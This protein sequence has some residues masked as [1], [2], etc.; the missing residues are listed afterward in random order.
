MGV[1]DIPSPYL[2]AVDDWL[3]HFMPAAMTLVLW[4]AAGAVLCMELYRLT[5]PQRHIAEIKLA[6]V[7][8]RRQVA[9]FD[10]EMEEAWPHIRRMLSLAMHRVAITLPA[11]V[12]ASLPLLLVIVWLDN[13]YGD[14]YPPP[15][16]P[17][18]VQVAG[19]FEGRWVNGGG[20]VPRAAVVDRGGA[21]VAEVPVA[22]PVSIIHK[23]RWW[24]M[25]IGNPA[26]YLPDDL[27]FDRIDIALPRQQILSVGPAWLRGWEAIFFAALILV[28]LG[29]KTVR[30]VA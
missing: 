3:T 17:V 4:A 26:G 9:E 30:G 2:S 13:R 18:S 19:G 15:N 10:G 23:R 11:T 14:A 1:L 12:V 20:D 5:S 16:V 6:L 7:R 24:N 21:P 27:P 28:S 29:F 25:L 8:A 22:E